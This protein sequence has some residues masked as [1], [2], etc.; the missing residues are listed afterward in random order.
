MKTRGKKY[1][2]KAALVKSQDALSPKEALQ[3]VKDAAFA[4][5]DETVEVHFGL[6]IDPKQADQQLRGTLV[7]PHGSGKDVRVLVFAQGEQLIAAKDAG[8]DFVGGEDLVEKIQGGWFDFDLVVAAPDMMAKISKLG[9]TLGAKGLMPNPKSGTVT[10][11]IATA[12]KEFKSGKLEYRNDKAGLIH[13][14]IGKKSFSNEQLL[15]NFKAVYDTIQKVKPNKSKGVY[16]KSITLCTTMG[17][18][19]RVEPSRLKWKEEQ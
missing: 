11:N 5:F 8:A 4:K 3:L 12:V 19:V 16:L 14:R 7:L 15:D 13:M 18:G 17:P 6:G 9:K 2:E 10:P 1:I